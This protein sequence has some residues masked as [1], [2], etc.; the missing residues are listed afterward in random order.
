[1]ATTSEPKQEVMPSLRRKNKE[2]RLLVK[3]SVSRNAC[4]NYFNGEL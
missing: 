4:A 3:T 2:M 1:M